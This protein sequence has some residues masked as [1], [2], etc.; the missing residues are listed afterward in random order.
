MA[1]YNLENVTNSTSLLGMFEG[2]NN[3]SGGYFAI[4]LLVAIAVVMIISLKHQDTKSVFV[5]VSSAMTLITVLFSTAGLIPITLVGLPVGLFFISL[6]VKL[7]TE[8]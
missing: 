1:V 8:D 6:V 7:T 3:I 4:I 5:Y 2:V